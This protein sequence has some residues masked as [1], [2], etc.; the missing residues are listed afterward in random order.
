MKSLRLQSLVLIFSVFLAAIA[1]SASRYVDANS[2]TPAPPYTSWATAARVIQDAINIASTGDD[3]LV[4]N[5]VY[6]TGGKPVSGVLTN[7]VAVDKPITVRS[8]NGAQ[9]TLI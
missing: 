5:G 8:V 9:F 4:T 6:A 1:S 2:A 3:V 7:R